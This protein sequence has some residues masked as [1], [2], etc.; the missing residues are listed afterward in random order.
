MREDSV[1]GRW[2]GESRIAIILLVGLFI[3]RS[4]VAQRDMVREG[5]AKSAIVAP[6]GVGGLSALAVSELQK[7]IGELTGGRVEIVE[8]TAVGGLPKDQ[9]LILVG[10]PE[11]NLLVK[12]AV[13]AGQVD[14]RGLKPEGFLLKTIEVEGR[15]ALVIGG[16]D[17]AGTL[18]GAYDWLERQGIVFQIS[19]DIIPNHKDTLPL[20]RLDVR[21]EPAFSQRGFGIASC[22]E[23]R[24]IWSYPDI[25]NFIDQMAK[26]KLNYLIWHMFSPEPY[27][28]YSYAGEKKLMG[29]RSSW[30]G[31]YTLPGYNFGSYKVEDYFVSKAAF[32]KFGKEYMAPDEWQGVENQD[33]VFASARDLLQ[34]TIRYAKTRNIKVWVAL[35]SLNE[36]DPNIARYCR[37][38]G[39]PS[40]YGAFNGAYVCPT[41][42]TVHQI[43]ELRFKSLVESYPEAAGFI[44]WV[45]ESYPVCHHPEDD[46]LF[47]KERP[48]YAEAKE[49]LIKTLW[50]P[51]KTPDAFIDNCIGAVH[52]VEK[53]LE[54]RDRISP[55]TKIGVGMWGRAFLLPTLDKLLPKDVLLVDNETSGVWTPDGV[56]MEYYGG[57]GERDR[58]FMHEGDDDSGMIGMQFHVRLYY[59]DGMLERALENGAQ[60]VTEFGDRFRSEEHLAKYMADGAWN[61]HL[62]PDQFYHDYA[63][64][65]FGERA[66][67][68]MFQAFMT[69]EDMEGYHGYH[70]HKLHHILLME[71]CS[72]PVELETA[73]QYA[74]QPNPYDGPTFKD[75]KEFA[76]AIPQRIELFTGERDLLEKALGYM[77][78]AEAVAAPGSLGEVHYLENKTRAYSQM[79]GAF[80]QLDHAFADFG[81]AFQLDPLMQ[82]QEFLKRLDASQMEF[83]KARLLGRYSAETWAQYVDNVSDVGVLWRLNTFVVT[84]MDLIA[85]F[86]QTINNYHH[87]KPYLTRVEWEKIFSPLP[88]IQWRPAHEY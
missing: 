25:V 35:E 44:F 2:R 58:I 61:P 79:M 18:Y 55:T 56:P 63:R 8:P 64:R 50:S 23:M 76:Q 62:T 84:G 38:G 77:Q 3:C 83:E 67:G 1:L 49:R 74:E 66:E 57:M 7:Y 43:N 80:I 4:A 81:Q 54:V 42:P 15:P 36:L 82:R 6:Q 60:G 17:E 78:A 5:Q 32:Q 13:A 30:E 14:F 70:E 65:I 51:E 88:I 40:P 34:R 10:G 27:L 41:D 28:E 85:Q 26:L 86:M 19:K 72:P 39:Y 75:W 71:C 9:V 29:D 46:A 52:L 73:K 87:G 20:N 69:L 53:I 59:H 48:K 22:Y 16:N 33:R 45:N 47:E 12:R 24:S 68:L 37:R 31:G 21:S 11:V